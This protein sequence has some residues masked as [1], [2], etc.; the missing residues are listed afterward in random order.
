MAAFNPLV[1]RNDG[2]YS[3][4]M[5]RTARESLGIDRV[6]LACRARVGLRTI[7]AIEI[8]ESSPRLD[9]RRKLLQALRI[10]L[11]E[12]TRIFGPLPKLGRQG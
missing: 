12:H 11:R 8:G 9:T 3:T 2:G 1:K 10:P 6:T 7:V 4:R 5:L